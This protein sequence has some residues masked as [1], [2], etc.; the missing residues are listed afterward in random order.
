MA[1]KLGPEEKA[2]HR[3]VGEVLHYLWDPCGVA[4]A[5]QARDE[6]DTYVDGICALLWQGAGSTTISLHLMQ[7]AEQ[8][9]G[10]VDTGE[11]ADRVA[12]RLVEWRDVVTR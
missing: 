2:L 7:I 11:H 1:E 6:Y 10:L 4:G 5:P 8:N 3:A 9:M 12:R